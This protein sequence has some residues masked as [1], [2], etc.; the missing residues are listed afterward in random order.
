MDFLNV[1]VAGILLGGIYALVAIGLNL[2]FGV[3]RV[4]N[5]AHGEFVMLGM[6]GA[7]LASAVASIDPYVAVLLIGPAGFL[8]G[9]I[10]Q[11]LVIEP[12]L[13]E[14][15]MQIFATFGLV[16]IF[17]NAV[18][19][20][21]RGE[22]KSV[23]SGA[24]TASL[25]L[26]V[27]VSVPRLIVLVVATALAV[28]LVFYLRRST[29]GTAIRA[30]SQDRVTA[31][32]M[33]IDVKRAYL[34]TFGL[35][36]ALACVAGAL[37]APVYTA[38]PSIGFQFIMPAFAVVVLGG[39]GSVAGSYLGGMIVGLVEAFSGFYLDPALKQA[40]WFTLF[41]VALVVRPAGLLGQRGSEE[42]GRP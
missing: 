1:L 21:T 25:D 6:Y 12:L 18:L 31:R 27:A 34:L 41:L 10:V 30:V 40:I 17:Q 14:P 35:A 37:L 26:G 29:F 16:I 4:V 33:G 39:L 42:F 32:L 8:L 24:S 13:D 15:L 38:T 5:F 20:L 23:R 3:I 36:T 7:Y 11:K 28:A 2:V 22:S 9:L 19:A